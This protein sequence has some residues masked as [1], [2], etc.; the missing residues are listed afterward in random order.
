[1]PLHCAVKNRFLGIARMLLEKGADPNSV[2]D[3][4]PLMIASGLG[5]KEM[6]ELLIHYGADVKKK[7]DK[8]TSLHC[9]AAGGYFDIMIL[10]LQKGAKLR[11]IV[12]SSG[13]TVLHLAVRDV[14]CK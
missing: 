8:G 12:D 5:H 10:L 3:Q 9:A 7:S 4:V 13:C 1:M 6:V 14:I 11:A 2:D